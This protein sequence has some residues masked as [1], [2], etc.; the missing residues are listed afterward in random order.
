MMA[1]GRNNDVKKIVKNVVGVGGIWPRVK[2][3]IMKWSTKHIIMEKNL[4]IYKV[5]VFT[6]QIPNR[7]IRLFPSFKV[8]GGHFLL[9]LLYHGVHSSH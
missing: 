5:D 1:N 8:M 6:L 4:C 2:F 3:H 7:P 9:S